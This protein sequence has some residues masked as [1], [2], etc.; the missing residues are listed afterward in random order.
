MKKIILLVF[1]WLVVVNVFAL[2]GFNRFNLN[3][4]TAYQWMAWS[5]F[6]VKPSWNIIDLHNRWDSYWYLDIVQNGYYMRGAGNLA[7][8]AFFP[9]Y[10]LLIK[11]TGTLFLKNFVLGGWI[12]S[13]IFL[14]LSAI[15][16]H[17]FTKEFHPKIE[18]KWPVIFLLVYPFA[19]FLNVIYTESLFLFL[20]IICFYFA[21]KKK[22]WLAGLF[23]FL[24]ALAHSNGLFL[25]IPILWQYFEQYRFKIR[26][27]IVAI[28]LA[29]LGTLSIPAYHYFKFHDFFL[30]FK[31]QTWWGRSFSINW[32]HLQF[33]SH[34]STTNILIDASFMLLAAISTYF[35]WK[36]ISPMYAVYMLGTIVSALSS[37]TMMS[38]GRY[39]LVLFPLY[40]WL[41]SVKNENFRLGWLLTSALLLALDIILWVN[42]YWAG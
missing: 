40:I 13:I 42:Y 28:L 25:F 8:V 35:V 12:T 26:P 33:F 9:L 23:A 24:G 32:D 27:P 6:S 41:A 4:D 22:L 16:L 5:D 39:L 30:F 18:A 7:N 36:K 3:Q 14:F 17:K 10:P 34:P 37:G 15:F 2:V 29:P 19:F 38:I 31:I 11:I 20:S 21:L 1:V